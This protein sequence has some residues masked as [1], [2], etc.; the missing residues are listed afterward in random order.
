MSNLHPVDR[1]ALV[2]AAERA[3]EHA[4]R[5]QRRARRARPLPDHPEPDLQ[6]TELDLG[7]AFGEVARLH[8]RDD[9]D[10]PGGLDRDRLLARLHHVRDGC[11]TGSSTLEQEL[12]WF[13]TLS[14]PLLDQLADRLVDDAA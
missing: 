7:R 2:M 14:D 12:A 9:V 8:L 4:Q 1:L 10:E 6:P 3:D 5:R 13:Q 11:A